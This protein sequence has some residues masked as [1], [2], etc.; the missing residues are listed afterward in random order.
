MKKRT[1]DDWFPFWIDK[2]LLGST[3]DELTVEQCAVWVDFLAL[4]YK[5]DGYIRANEGIPYPLKRLAGL[6]NRPEELIQQTI[7]RCLESD[8]NKLRREPDGTLYVISHP[9]YELSKRHKSRLKE[10][11][12]IREDEIFNK[13]AIQCPSNFLDMANKS[14]TVRVSRLIVA[15]II[16]RS[17]KPEEEVHHR[18]KKED[19]NWPKNLMLFK[20]HADHTRYEHGKKVVPIWDGSDIDDKTAMVAIKTATKSRGEKSRGEKSRGEENREDYPPEFESFW[21]NYPKKKEKKDAYFTWK[22]LTKKQNEEVIV[23]A[24]HYK[25]ETDAKETEE[26]YIKN[27]KTFLNKK[28]EKWKDYLEP[29]KIKKK[30]TRQEKEEEKMKDWEKKED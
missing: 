10:N 7:D 29:P 5:D 23:A 3:R 2:W 28:K 9:D 1:G 25:M 20:N 19:D 8:V 22:T 6:L 27:A 21:K 30:L 17:L 14:G 12:E 13:I 24:K 15:I 18:N 4:S 16:G 26:E 11:E